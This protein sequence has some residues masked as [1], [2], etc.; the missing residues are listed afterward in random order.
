MT[1]LITNNIFQ[2]ADNDT[3]LP[4]TLSNIS[5]PVFVQP[6][7][8]KP[9]LPPAQQEK[10]ESIPPT[11]VFVQ[12]FPETLPFPPVQQTEFEPSPPAPVFVQPPPVSP[13][14]QAR[15]DSLPLSDSSMDEDI[16]EHPVSN[17]SLLTGDFLMDFSVDP[18]LCDSPIDRPPSS[19]FTSE[20][21]SAWA[22]EPD[23]PLL[24]SV[25]ATKQ[26]GLLD[27][28]S[29]VPSEEPH[30]RWRKRK[31]EN[32]EKDQEEYAER[33]K[34]DEAEKLRKQNHRREKNKISQKRRRERLKKEKDRAKLQDSSVSFFCY[35][36]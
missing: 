23:L 36:L 33:K 31:R 7:P 29:K 5:P 12:P 35:A 4:F 1:L 17:H 9:P 2:T 28:F 3:S 27:F 6:L 13:V 20:T 10:V 24:S 34:R 11:P 25:K 26:T 8:D 15:V 32:Q 16:P 21:S 22:S 30:A 18:E 19:T 14:Q